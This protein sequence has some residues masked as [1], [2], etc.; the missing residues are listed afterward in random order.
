MNIPIPLKSESVFIQTAI[1]KQAIT[2]IAYYIWMP[3]DGMLKKGF[4]S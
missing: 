4:L 1:K 2:A 3:T